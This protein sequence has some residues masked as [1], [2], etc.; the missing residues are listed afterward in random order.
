MNKSQVRN[1]FVKG[2]PKPKGQSFPRREAAASLLMSITTTRVHGN[3]KGGELVK[4]TW[5]WGKRG[6]ET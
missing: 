6:L 1:S 2:K 4:V 5:P 3:D